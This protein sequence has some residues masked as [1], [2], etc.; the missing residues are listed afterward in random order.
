ML[1]EYDA[2]ECA[3]RHDKDGNSVAS[4]SIIR[5]A[6]FASAALPLLGKGWTFRHGK[7]RQQIIAAKLTPSQLYR[8]VSCAHGASV[9]NRLLL[10]KRKDTD[11]VN[12]YGLVTCTV[13]DWRE[14]NSAVCL[15]AASVLLESFRPTE[16]RDFWT[17]ARFVSDF[18]VLLISRKGQRIRS[19]LE[20]NFRNVLIGLPVDY[21]MEPRKPAAPKR[22][23]KRRPSPRRSTVSSARLSA[24]ALH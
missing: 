10:G 22:T 8:L 15:A 1:D 23:K 17:F 12:Y 6:E 7:L 9:S 14:A 16:P 13:E 24:A 11:R 21:G 2:A 5:S 19:R 3:I 20:R 4:L 18:R